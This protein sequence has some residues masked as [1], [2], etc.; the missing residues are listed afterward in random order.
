MEQ[1]SGDFLAAVDGLRTLLD[2]V[3][4]VWPISVGQ[5]TVCAE[6]E[7]G[8]T[9]RGEVEVDVGQSQGRRI[10][11]IWPIRRLVFIQGLLRLF[12]SSRPSSLS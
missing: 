2:C 10:R 7:D 9:A 4:R 11:R 12:Q 8:S 3:G 5:A 1:Y 6:Y